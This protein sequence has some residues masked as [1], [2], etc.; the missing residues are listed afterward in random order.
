MCSS[1]CAPTSS[2]NYGLCQQADI[3]QQELSCRSLTYCIAA[4]SVKS[5]VLQCGQV[6]FQSCA[7][8][9]VCLD[10]RV[11]LIAEEGRLPARGV[12]DFFFCSANDSEKLVLMKAR[13][14]L[15][16][17]TL[18][19]SLQ[20][21]SAFLSG[22]KG[23][24]HGTETLKQLRR[25]SLELETLSLLYW[26]CKSQRS[27]N[28]TWVLKNDSIISCKPDM[29]STSIASHDAFAHFCERVLTCQL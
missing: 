3:N 5:R 28:G 19:G 8:T 12:T 29:S 2:S 6:T 16:S 14:K 20:D 15:G 25:S 10:W 27:T 24:S 26:H 7:S 22:T 1:Y 4:R 17:A 21:R 9:L 13:N 11:P 23:L 18:C